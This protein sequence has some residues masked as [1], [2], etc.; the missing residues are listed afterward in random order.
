MFQIGVAFGESAIL[1]CGGVFNRTETLTVG[2]AL[3]NALRSEGHAING[4]TVIVHESCF[5]HVD[6][7]LYRGTEIVDEE[8][9][10]FYKLDLKFRGRGIKI[11][12]D[13]MKI[14]A[15]FSVRELQQSQEKLQ[16]NV[17]QCAIPFIKIDQQDFAS[18]IRSLTVMFV[19]LGVDLTSA[20]SDAGIDKIQ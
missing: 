3:M 2:P 16:M 1:Y 19:S 6:E 7:T 17:T 18:E 5:N 4:G 20:Y 10:S 11:S 15:Q 9:D 8:G 12:S 14:R 13:V